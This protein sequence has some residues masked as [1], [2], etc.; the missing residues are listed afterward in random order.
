MKRI[1]IILFI[2]F[3]QLQFGYA[4][5]FKSFSEDIS[6]YPEEI[7]T[8][9]ANSLKEGD[10]L[11]FDGFTVDWNSGMF[12]DEEKNRIITVSNQ[13]LKRKARPYPHFKAYINTILLFKEPDRG[14]INYDK[15]EEGLMSLIKDKNLRFAIQFF[16]STTDLLTSR[17]L[18]L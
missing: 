13:L 12:S 18:S 10:A 9:F 6:L 3:V 15:W 1:L 8:F 14:N 7:K 5:Q 17:R 4:Q 2:G 11:F 16:K